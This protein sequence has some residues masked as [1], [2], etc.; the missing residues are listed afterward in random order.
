MKFL[1]VRFRKQ[2]AIQLGLGLFRDDID[3]IAGLNDIDADRVAKKR[4]G[5][6]IR[7]QAFPASV[8]TS[9]LDR[10]RSRK[11]AG[12]FCVGARAANICSGRLPR[13]Q[14]PWVLA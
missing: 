7:G 5:E 12:N 10:W 9:G 11:D 14:G 8:K 3:L 13:A 1:R 2:A 4:V 6:F